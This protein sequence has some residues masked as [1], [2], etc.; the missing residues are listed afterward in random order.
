MKGQWRKFGRLNGSDLGRM[1]IRVH[2]CQKCGMWHE[3]AK[4]DQCHTCGVLA[5]FDHFDSKGE[6]KRWAQLRLLERSGQI[7]ALRRQ[8]SYPLL[9]V[10]REGLPVRFAYYVADYVYEENGIEVIEDHKAPSGISPE[11]AL[12]LRVMEAAGRPVKLTS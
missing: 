9:T 4:P 11:A 10:G 7:T 6:A 8:V 12:K 2:I 5:T 3:G 1:A